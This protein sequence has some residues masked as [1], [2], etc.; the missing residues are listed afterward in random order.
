MHT[1]NEIAKKTY[2]WTNQQEI[3]CFKKLTRTMAYIIQQWK[4]IYELIN[5]RNLFYF[6][7]KYL[8]TLIFIRRTQL[9]TCKALM[10][11]VFTILTIK[12]LNSL[13][14]FYNSQANFYIIIWS[15]KTTSKMN[16]YKKDNI[17]QLPSW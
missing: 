6:L 17:H 3:F 16:I 15:G 13:Q 11:T 9:T 12:R 5:K 8:S 10:L 4:H 2:I 7:Q 14:L 1:W